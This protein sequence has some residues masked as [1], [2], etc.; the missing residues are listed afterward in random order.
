MRLIS[1][2]DGPCASPCFA[3]AR[4][5][6]AGRARGGWLRT[7]LSCRTAPDRCRRRASR[8]GAGRQRGHREQ[9]TGCERGRRACAG[10]VDLGRQRRGGSGRRC[11]RPYERC[12]RPIGWCVRP[13]R[14]R[15]LRQHATV[16]RAQHVPLHELRIRHVQ[17]A[18]SSRR[19]ARRIAR[20][21][22]GHTA[23]RGRT[24]GCS[25]HDERPCRQRSQRHVHPTATLCQ[26]ARPWISR[27]REGMLRHSRSPG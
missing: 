8:S 26:A 12:R 10:D 21:R 15:A 13:L 20:G 3:H 1:I 27:R 17:V 22:E 2:A 11:C 23:E 6:R 9:R 24:T 16:H 5:C 18:A 7:G 14:Q 4:L 19:A 25:A